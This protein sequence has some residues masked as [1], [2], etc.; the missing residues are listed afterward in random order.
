MPTILILILAASLV[1]TRLY[2][3]LREAHTAG[4]I[5]PGIDTLAALLLL[6]Y[7]LIFS[8]PMTVRQGNRFS[9][10]LLFSELLHHPHILT[11]LEVGI[12]DDIPFMVTAYAPLGTLRDWLA[13]RSYRPFPQQLA[14]SILLEVGEAL[15]YI[16]R[17]Q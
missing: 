16:H 6:R 13:R 2:L 1:I 12:Q 11:I 14:V 10:K 4:S 15:Q 17:H 8:S 9:K 5:W 7:R 3:V